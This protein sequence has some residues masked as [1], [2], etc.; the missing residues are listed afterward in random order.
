MY[1][2]KIAD[3]HIPELYRIAKSRGIHMTMLV[4]EFIERALSDIRKNNGRDSGS[5]ESLKR[6]VS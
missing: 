5:M 6:I 4:N 3:K 1:S 2:P